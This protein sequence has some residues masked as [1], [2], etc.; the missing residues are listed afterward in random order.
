MDMEHTTLDVLNIQRM[1]QAVGERCACLVRVPGKDEAWIKRVLDTGVDGIIV[2]HVSTVDEVRNIIE[3]C[4][5]PPEGSRSVG[6][7]RAQ[8]YGLQFDDYMKNSNQ[9]V[10]IIPQI[11]HI[12]GVQNIEEIVNVPGISAVFVGPFD[13]SGSLRKLG[14]IQDAQV[15]KS[16]IRVN[17]ACIQ[18]GFPVG[19]FCMD[20][21]IASSYIEHGF[22]LVNVGMD[23]LFIAESS[24]DTLRKLRK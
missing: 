21:E 10:A 9:A 15:Q 19:I 11:E 20:A 14:E 3:T 24:K 23:I 13:L 5:Y 4:L 22:T 17:E 18:A 6:L 1:L 8:K 16:I 12:D 2:P 7:A